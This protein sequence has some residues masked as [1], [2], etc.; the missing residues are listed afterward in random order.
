[1]PIRF[2][3]PVV[4]RATPDMPQPAAMPRVAPLQPLPAAAPPPV[5]TAS[6]A[7]GTML[8][9]Q[10]LAKASGASPTGSGASPAPSPEAQLALLQGL[11]WGAP[12]F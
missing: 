7:L 4:P 6:Q 10:N 2:V 3:S 9:L 8:A 5:N 12:L 1:M 11:P